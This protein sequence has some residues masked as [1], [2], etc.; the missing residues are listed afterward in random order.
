[1]SLIRLLLIYF[2]FKNV[3]TL[4]ALIVGL[5]RNLTIDGYYASV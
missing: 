4:V 5:P 2:N 1:M 3:E